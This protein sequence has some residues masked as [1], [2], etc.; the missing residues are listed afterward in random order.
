[1][2]RLLSALLL[3]LMTMP[4]LA[5]SQS[6]VPPK[7]PLVWGSS[8]GSAYIRSIP[9]PSQIG[10]QNCAASLTD[11]FP[12]L[13]FV[14]SVAGGCPPFGADFNGI[15]KQITQWNQW[16]QAAGPIFYDSGFAAS[17]GGYPSGAILSSAVVPGDQW[18]S[19]VDNNT[20]NPDL[21]SGNQIVGGSNWVQL[22]GQV[23]IGTPVPSFSLTALPG[24]VLATTG[25]IGNA[26]SN[27]TARANADT[28]SL[29]ASLWANCPNATCPI[30]TST[31]AGST[32]GAN[33][34]ADYA[35]NKALATP[36]MQGAGLIGAD[37]ASAFLA[38]V[39]VSVGS[40]TTTASILGENL[41]ALT[42]GENGPHTHTITDPGHTHSYSVAST[43]ANQAAVQPAHAF[44]DTVGPA[45]TGSSTTGIT[46]NSS[47]SGTGHNTV[48]RSFTV[49]WMLK[50]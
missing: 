28:Q 30:F 16:Q 37:E 29:F 42:S 5:L 13:T 31:G 20:S 15:F 6:S 4:A 24:Y 40:S 23:P 17:I 33:A 32:R 25:T 49:R 7:F 8:A 48:E 9:I 45:T 2:K 10:T 3:M 39:P 46:I 36:E 34:A 12:P 18:M 14:P 43:T 22:P 44:L 21:L 35:A 41:H 19:I 26:A 11:G 27:G 38:G 50:L 1:M 47:G